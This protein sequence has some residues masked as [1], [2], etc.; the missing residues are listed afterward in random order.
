LDDLQGGYFTQAQVDRWINNAHREAQKVL[1]RAG[2][3]FFVKWVKT[4]CVVNQYDYALPEDF[5][6][7]H[8]LEIVSSGSPPN[9]NLQPLMPITINQQDLVSSGSG[10]P[11]VYFIWKNKINIRP[12]PDSTYVMRLHYSPTVADMAND[13]DQPDL[14]EAYHEYIA[15]L[16]SIDGMLKDGRDISSLTMKKEHYE[17][18]MKQDSN[19]RNQDGPRTVTLSGDGYAYG[20]YF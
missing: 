20:S 15:V 16:A 4:N 7:L 8:R 5:T 13:T 11:Q 19:E 9:E 14:P 1:L 12:A 2:Q 17:N 18:L 3:N 10:R 6:K